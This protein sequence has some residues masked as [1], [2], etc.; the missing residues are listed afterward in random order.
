M[1]DLHQHSVYSDGT[2]SLEELVENNRRRGI[3]CFALTDHDTT[4]GCKALV[5]SLKNKGE[6]DSGLFITGIEFSTDDDGNDVHILAYD[7]DPEDE[8][9][10]EFVARGQALRRERIERLLAHLK[11]EHGITFNDERMKKIEESPNPNKPMIAG[12]LVEMGYAKTIGEAIRTYL[13]IRFPSLKLTSREV[14][15]GLNDTDALTVY[16]HPLG[17]N[18]EYPFET[19]KKR[20]ERFRGY[21]L[22]GLESWYSI[23][24][25]R[26]CAALHELALGSGLLVSCGSDYHGKNK[27]IPL[28]QVCCDAATIPYDEITLPN[29]CK[30]VY[31]I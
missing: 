14:I 18:R 8:R 4:E 31:H 26:E 3:Y 21:G 30:H 2:D 6:G 9:V 13:E 25:A 29:A 22:K 12:F 23:Y 10:N 5:K 15:E 24:S 11:K 27:T 20:L 19:V 17:E 16:A 7:F 28:G 1:I